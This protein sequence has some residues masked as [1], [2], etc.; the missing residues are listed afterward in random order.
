M[1]NRRMLRTT[2]NDGG[3]NEDADDY[4]DDNDDGGDPIT[5]IKMFFNKRNLKASA[6][7]CTTLP[8][9]INC[10]SVVRYLPSIRGESRL[11]I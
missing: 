3:D 5:Q 9:I 7:S 11:S 10:T 4:D 6:L 1:I 8:Y 2:T